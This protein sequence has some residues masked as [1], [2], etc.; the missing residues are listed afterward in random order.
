MKKYLY[1]AIIILVMVGLL[2]I[3]TYF[4]LSDFYVKYSLI[5]L[6]ISY[7]LGQYVQK[8]FK[9]RSAAKDTMEQKT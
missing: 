6:L 1:D 4:D 3:V 8:K 9:K 5:P 2:S 7:F